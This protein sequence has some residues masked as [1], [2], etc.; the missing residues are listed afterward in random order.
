MSTPSGNAPSS[1]TRNC[2]LRARLAFPTP[3]CATRSR[4]PG[5]QRVVVDQRQASRP[6]A[7][8]PGTQPSLTDFDAACAPASC[9]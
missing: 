6:F 4:S 8:R 3:T 5:G 9:W 2:L 7:A 1:S